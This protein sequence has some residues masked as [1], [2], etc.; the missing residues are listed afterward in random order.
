MTNAKPLALIAIGGNSIIKG[1]ERGTIGEQFVN[2]EE[3]CRSIVQIVLRGYRV[4]ITHGNGP[5]VGAQLL[6]SELAQHQVYTHPLDVCV[7]DTQGSMGYMIQ[8]SLQRALDDGG[9]TDEVG[10]VV[11]QVV[12]REDDPAFGNPTKP[13]GPYYTAEEAGE[14]TKRLGWH[15]TED[16]ERGFRRVV[17]SP[18]PHEI[19]E[20]R[21]IRAAVEDDIIVIAVGGGGVPVVRRADRLYGVEAVVD[22]DRASALLARLVN[23]DLFIISTD[24]EKVCLNYRQPGQRTLDRVAA[25]D[26]KRYMA[27]GHFPP[28]SMGPKIESVIQFLESG[29][30]HA[31]ITS[32]ENLGR[33]VDGD[34]GTHFYNEIPEGT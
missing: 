11:T 17:A 5:Q 1:G 23:A 26:A 30:V 12:V 24:I 16:A 18:V 7:A 2:I 28:G 27:E 19:V 8:N 29:G 3:T 22:K 4:I 31:I 32:P 10:S 34:T 15:M 20:H 33:A 21:M 25:T 6:R 14:K 13:V 9:R